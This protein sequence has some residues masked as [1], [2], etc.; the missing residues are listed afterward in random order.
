MIYSRGPSICLGT[1]SAGTAPTNYQDK[2]VGKIVT[3][4]KPCRLGG[5]GVGKENI[6]IVGKCRQDSPGKVIKLINVKPGIRGMVEG[7]MT[8]NSRGFISYAK[9]KL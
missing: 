1:S 3:G 9:G 4:R 8:G 6:L 5:E 7:I 2:I